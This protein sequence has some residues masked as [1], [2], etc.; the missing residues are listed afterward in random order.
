MTLETWKDLPDA[1]IHAKLIQ[2]RGIGRFKLISLRPQIQLYLSP[3]NFHPE[4]EPIPFSFPKGFAG[5]LVGS[6][7]LFKTL[8]WPID[9]WTPSAGLGSRWRR[10]SRAGAC[11]G[12]ARASVQFHGSGAG[13]GDYWLRIG[14]GRC[15]S[16]EGDAPAPDLVV[17]T[18]DT[19]W[20]RIVRGELDGSLV[21]A[22]VLLAGLDESDAA[23]RELLSGW[24]IR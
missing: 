5:S 7:G 8:G 19:V 14:D 1:D 10:G 20:M 11:G 2:I 16:F 15:E 6:L 12:A 22:L 23:P 3:I 9:T 13:P 17:H 24:M 21:D 4:F 18:P